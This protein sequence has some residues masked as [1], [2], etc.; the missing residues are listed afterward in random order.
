MENERAVKGREVTLVTL[1]PG[2]FQPICGH[3]EA[4]GQSILHVP[5]FGL[6]WIISCL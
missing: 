1:S 2:E 4:L 3:H 6:G 5:G